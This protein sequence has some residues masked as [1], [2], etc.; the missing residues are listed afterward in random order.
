MAVEV[1]VDAGV[2]RWV[3]QLAELSGT[4]GGATVHELRLVVRSSSDPVLV[5]V[6]K[7]ALQNGG[8]LCLIHEC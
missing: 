6:G 7:Y 5:K 1:G 4:A 3:E 8:Y 2:P